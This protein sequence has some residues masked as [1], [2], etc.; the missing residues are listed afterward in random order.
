MSVTR[1]I[2]GSRQTMSRTGIPPLPAPTW[3]RCA[4]SILEFK[5]TG[6]T[7]ENA[8]EYKKE[9]QKPLIGSLPGFGTISFVFLCVL[10]GEI[11]LFR[12][13]NGPFAGFVPYFIA[14]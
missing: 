8:E 13:G 11:A 6:E 4:T 12:L 9:K 10:C 7:A 5:P 2:R 3:S 1:A 14:R